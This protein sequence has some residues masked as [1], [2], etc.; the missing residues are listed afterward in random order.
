[1]I[2]NQILI[3]KVKQLPN[4]ACLQFPSATLYKCTSEVKG[5]FALKDDVYHPHLKS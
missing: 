3:G 4:L 1:M 2:S 5:K